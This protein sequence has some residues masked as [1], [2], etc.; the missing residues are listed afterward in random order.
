MVPSL[1][2]RVI[3]L[4]IFVTLFIK[5]CLAVLYSDAERMGG[6]RLCEKCN[7]RCQERLV[8]VDKCI[9]LEDM[10]I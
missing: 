9:F 8:F 4:F 2:S 7:F 10:V 1:V 5:V 3:I 6:R